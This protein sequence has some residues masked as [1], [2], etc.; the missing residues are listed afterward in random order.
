M[1]RNEVSKQCSPNK[2][3]LL[4]GAYAKLSATNYVSDRGSG[5]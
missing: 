4:R 2:M 1:S 5:R 3:I